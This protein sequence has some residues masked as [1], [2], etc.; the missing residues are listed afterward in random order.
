MIHL[1]LNDSR[2]H[3]WF[4]FS[5]T[6]QLLMSLSHIPEWLTF[7]RTTHL[8]M[9]DSPFH[10]WINFWYMIH[11]LLNDSTINSLLLNDEWHTFSFFMIHFFIVLTFSPFAERFTFS[12]WFFNDSP[13]MIHLFMYDSRFHVWFTFSCM[14]HLFMYESPFIYAS[15]FPERFTYHE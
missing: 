15:S 11:L 2:F 9:Y 8:F 5:C 7:C 12:C 6:F 1:L 4:S 10:V 3:V 13:R 14:I